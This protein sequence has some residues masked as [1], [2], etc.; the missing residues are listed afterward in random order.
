MQVKHVTRVGFAARR[1]AQEER[2]LP[3]GP[4]LARQIIIN[5]QRVLAAVAE[6]LAH[7]AA[8]VRCDEL[9]RGRIRRGR[10]DNDGV[11]HCAVLFEFAYHVDDGRSLLADRDVNADEVL[12][13]LV[14]DGVDGH[15]G[16]AGLAVADD[17]FALT[18]TDRHHGIDGLEAGLHRLVH[19]FAPHHAGR[20]LLDDVALGGGDRAL[21]VDR[22]A[23]RIDHAAKKFGADRHI[24][25]TPGRLDG[26]A[27]LDVLVGTQHH[28][29]NR[30]ALKV[31]CQAEGVAREFEH[32][33][34][35]RGRQAVDAANAVGHRDHRTLGT[36]VG[37]GP[38][39]GDAALEQL[40][41][42][43]RIQLHG[44]LLGFS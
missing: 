44:Q 2:D 4:S 13:L 26:V 32:F 5:Y 25:N 37:S 24:K 15:R 36:Q 18:A 40:A 21:A 30:V 29:A 7:G 11:T 34:L 35:H 39:A 16:L 17:E 14:D 3:I 31:E 19:R 20:D 41:D 42:F 6:I 43:G 8:G 38:E 12:A 27:F 9:H 28:R 10:S 22:L 1:A 23:Q 33:A